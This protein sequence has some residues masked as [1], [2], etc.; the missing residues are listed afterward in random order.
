[1]K[2]LLRDWSRTRAAIGVVLV[3]AVLAG[4]LTGLPAAQADTAPVSATVPETVS[5]DP[6]PTW[7]VTGVV[8]SQVVVGNTV[9]ATGNF[10]KARPPG[11][12]Q[13]G[14]TE[15]DVSHLIAYDIRTGNR[16]AGFDH[17]L[18]A[19]GLAITASPDGSRIYVG[20][21]FTAVDG[22]ARGHVAAFDTA[23]GALVDNFAPV[24]NGQVKALAATNDTVYVGGAFQSAGGVAR[25]NLAAFSKTGVLQ[26]W[27]P[28]ADAYA[29]ALT[30]TPDGSKVVAGG[31]FATLNGVAVYGMGALDPVTGASLPWAANSVIQDSGKGAINSLTTDGSYIYGSGFAFGAGGRFEGTFSLNPGDGSIRWLT[32]CLGDTYDAEPVGGVV[33]AVSHAHNCT[34]IPGGFPDTSPRT[35]WQHAMAWTSSPTGVNNGP[36]AYGWN[37]KGQP[38]PSILQWYPDLGI[39]TATGQYQAAWNVSSGNGYLVLG[40][41][42]PTV[43]GKAQQGLTRFALKQAAPNKVGPT[44]EDTVPV[45]T[46][47]PATTAVATAPGTVRVTFGT[48]WDFD[49]QRLTYQVYRDRGTAAEKLVKTVNFDSNFWTVPNQFITDTGVPGGD[50]TYQVR[51]TDP[52]GNELLSP[53]SNTVSATGATLG[54]YPAQVGADGADH[55]WRLGESGTTAYDAVGDADGTAQAGVTRGAAGAVGADTDPASTF[56][57]TTSGYIGTGSA[58][59]QAPDTFSVEGWF[60]TASTSGGKLIGFG[61]ARTGNSGSYDRHVYLSNNGRL[62]FGVYPGSAKVISSATGYNDGQWHMFSASLSGEGMALYVDG[63]LVAR[64]RTVVAGQSYKG[65]WRIGGD[66][67]GSWPSAGTS[68]YVNATMDEVATYPTA[69]TA[70]QVNDHFVKSGRASTAPNQAPADAYGADVYNADPTLYWRLGESGGPVAADTA[71]GDN[72]GVYQGNPTY[73]QAGA[74]TTSPDKAVGV[75]TGS[76]YVTSASNFYAP[77]EYSQEVWFKTSTT[78]G[79]KLLGFGSSATGL[80]TTVDRN[81][82]MT[83]AGKLRFGTLNGAAQVT[84]DSPLS[85]NDNKWHHAVATQSPEGMRLYVDGVLVASNPSAVSSTFTGFWRAGYDRVWSGS[86]TSFFAGSLDEVAVYPRALSLAQIKNRFRAGGGTVANTPPIASF[87]FSAA[88]LRTAFS[89]ASSSDPDGTLSSYAWD[90]GDGTTAAGPTPERLYRAGGSYTVKLT[91]T[92]N[93]GASRTVQQSVTVTNGVPTAGFDLTSDQLDVSVDGGRSADSDGTITEYA[94]NFG[95]GSP[96]VRG[97]TATHRYTGG[98]V[99]TITL[100]VTDNAGGTSSTTQTVDVRATD[101]PVARFSSSA[102]GL[103]VAFDGSGSSDPDGTVAAYSWDFGDGTG[104]TEAKPAHAYAAPGSYQVTLTVTDNQ[105]ATGRLTETVA[106]TNSSPT[107]TFDSTIEALTVTFD[108]SGSRDADGTVTSYGWDFGDGSAAGRGS[109]PSHTYRA[110]GTYPV[111]LTV[112]DDLGATG[113]KSG[114]VTVQP[115]NIKPTAAFGFTGDELTATFDARDSSDSDGTIASYAWDFGD[116]T[117]PGSGSQPSHSYATAG[118]YLVKLTVTDDDGATDS[119]SQSVTVSGPLARDDFERTLSSGWGSADAG[120]AWTYSGSTSLFSVANGAGAIR[121]NAGS[122]PTARLPISATDT[123]L[124]FSFAFDKAPTGGGQFVRAI[125][126]GD[127]SAGYEAKVWVKADGTMVVYLTKIVNGTETDLATRVLAGSFSPGTAYTVR[128]Q[129]WGG[130]TTNLRAKVWRSDAS[131]PASWAA[132]TTDATASLQGAGGIAIKAYLSGSATNAP[133]NLSVSQLLARPTGN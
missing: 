62:S 30:L 81:L 25:Q 94:W 85:Y 117:A 133:V 100:T 67:L 116:A 113:T 112:T 99:K 19:Q 98:G 93:A 38:A 103:R 14:P 126:R 31:Q 110:A 53:V 43:N 71:R 74:L 1:M 37:F 86:T 105:G 97:R 128:T 132:T 51:I 80:S 21:D 114:T 107:A 106:V 79:G 66:T 34:M 28:S 57:G 16:I 104:S 83:N 45:R 131:E 39:G 72:R 92:D 20:G 102:T 129:V 10:T 3:A 50:H 95:D 120:G 36:N 58:A 27:A 29:Y 84:I 44:Y 35:R 9:Y 69:L 40:G 68:A 82:T 123:D 88:G 42:F 63:R 47:V 87:T 56:N 73:G 60:K 75:G 101:A 6:L 127:Q 22:V 96:T 61:S 15:I 12:W 121:M 52:F 5:A 65:Y 118:T 124:R 70:A 89:A 26:S 32:D 59:T 108:A 49:N 77:T 7:Q 111:T 8:W 2:T 4:G 90:F 46:A 122:G 55:Y 115:A 33:Y 130:P 78:S 13:G 18:N 54:A 11:M 64:D 125:A 17:S 91:V 24:A 23:T 119:I 41:E 109:S 48:A 76:A